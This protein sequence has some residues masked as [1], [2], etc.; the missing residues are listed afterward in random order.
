MLRDL[1]GGVEFRAGA[2]G[3]DEGVDAAVHEAA[4]PADAGREDGRV[5]ADTGQVDAEGIL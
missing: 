3:L 5:A 1:V 2:L 4:V